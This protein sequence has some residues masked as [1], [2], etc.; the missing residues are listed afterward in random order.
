M[1]LPNE[2]IPVGFLGTGVAAPAERYS[3]ERS[4]RFNSADSAYLNRTPSTAGNRKT[5]TW[6]GWV[7]RSALG[8]K[9]LFGCMP[10]T[11]SYTG[12][13]FSPSDQLRFMLTPNAGFYTTNAVFRDLS[14]WYHVVCACDS[15]LADG[16]DRVKFYVN[17]VRQSVFLDFSAMPINTDTN[18]NSTTAHAIGRIDFSGGISYLDAYLADI[19]FIEGQAL[20]PTSFGEFDADTGIWNPKEFDQAYAYTLQDSYFSANDLRSSSNAVTSGV[21][22]D[23]TLNY[24]Q[25]FYGN[26]GANGA[27]L[28]FDVSSVPAGTRVYVRYWNAAEAAGQT[29]TATCKQVDTGGSDISGTAVSQTWTQGQKWNDGSGYITQVIATGAS[30]IRLLF[31]GNSNNSFGWGIGEVEAYSGYGTNGFHLPFSDNSSAA[32]LGDDTSGNNNDWT[33]NNISAATGLLSSTAT[34]SDYCVVTGGTIDTGR[35]IT[36][37]FDG[38]TTTMVVF[39]NDGNGVLEW[40]LILRNVST[41][42]VKLKSDGTN[43]VG[44]VT[45]SGNGLTSTQITGNNLL[46]FVSIP[47]TSSAV[48]NVTFTANSGRLTLS[49]IKVNSTTVVDGS[50]L[51]T[52]VTAYDASEGSD[53]DSLVDVPQNGTETDTGLGNEVRGNYATLNPLDKQNSPSF[54][55]GNLDFVGSASG[56]GVTRGTVAI[57]SGKYYWEATIL[58]SNISTNGI[59]VGIAALGEINA[60][61]SAVNAWSYESTQGRKSASG[62]VSSYGSTFTTGD[63][64]GIAFDADAGTLTFYKNNTSQGVAFSSGLPNPALPFVACYST[65]SIAINFGQRA[66]AYTAPSGFKALCTSNLPTPTVADGSTAMDVVTW[67]GTGGG[68]TLS[69]LGFSPDL[70][71]GKLRSA[72]SNHQLYDVVRGAGNANDLSSSLTAAEGSATTSASVYGYLSAFTSDGFTVA[73]GTDGNFPD[74]YWNE[75]AASYVAWTWDAGSSTVTNTDG[76]ITSSVRANPSAGFSIVTY[77]GTLSSAPNPAPTVGH[78]LGAKPALIISKSRDNSGDGGGW[79]VNH[80]YNYNNFLRLNTTAAAADISANGGGTTADPTS[81]V[82]STYYINGNNVSGATY[83]AYCFAPVEGY[84]SFGSYLGNG[85]SDGPM[86]YTGFRPRYILIKRTNSTSNWTIR[87]TAR[88]TYNTSI[89]DLYA[90]SSDAEPPVQAEI[91]I[92]SNGFKCRDAGGSATNASGSTYIYAAFAENPFSIARAR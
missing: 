10:A 3:I 51:A 25:T 50:A 43:T 64:I 84:S 15:T 21:L 81:A 85:S 92:L 65:D 55:N 75:S 76:S 40:Q 2:I 18:V 59:G 24:S 11:S 83:V 13:V 91:D 5:W 89:L 66:F 34:W 67:T 90:N 53:N 77:T 88:D 27:Y 71:W 78:G 74:A 54:S 12:I 1:S 52:G 69:G 6:A 9:N 79:Y 44:D 31:S 62:S 26:N 72:A 32:A 4:V 70:V 33:V 37:A 56:W 19:H 68:R 41:F 57:A 20:D 61:W 86:V 22:T 30:K 36:E 35:T 82:F 42:E 45:V 80:S 49:G 58:S 8:Y 14:A 48:S 16:N 23:G 29:I 60:S 39:T 73:N 46:T 47:V 28:D 87:D 7:K 38:D 17:G 63:V